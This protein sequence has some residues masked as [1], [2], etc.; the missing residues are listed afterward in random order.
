MEVCLVCGLLIV[1]SSVIGSNLIRTNGIFIGAIV[2]GL[3]GVVIA[4]RIAIYLSLAARSSLNSMIAFGISGFIL[5]IT[6]C[7]YN[8]KNPIIVV[9]STSLIGMGALLG[10][11]LKRKSESQV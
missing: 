6:I 10:D 4:S 7:F 11:Y 9:M 8:F 5:A 3:L 2:G 1:G